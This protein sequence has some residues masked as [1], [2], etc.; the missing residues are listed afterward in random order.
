[1]AQIEQCTGVGRTSVSGKPGLS[2]SMASSGDRG[3][4]FFSSWC[5]SLTSTEL[6]Q[7][8]AIS[9]RGKALAVFCIER[10]RHE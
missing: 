7:S 8:T 4:H 6:H 5:I 2:S 1:M 3:A 10:S 9:T